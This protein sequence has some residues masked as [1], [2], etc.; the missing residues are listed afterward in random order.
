M[1]LPAAMSPGAPDWSAVGSGQSLDI[2]AV[3]IGGWYGQGTRRAG[4]VAQY[5]LALLEMPVNDASAEPPVFL[6]FCK[7]ALDVTR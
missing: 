3:I 7:C 1:L 5:L 2:D 6:S 4:V